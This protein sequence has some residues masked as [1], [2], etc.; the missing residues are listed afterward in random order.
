[1]ND[2]YFVI[3]QDDNYDDFYT[4][5]NAQRARELAKSGRFQEF[6]PIDDNVSEPYI[7]ELLKAPDFLVFEEF[8]LLL[9]GID[10]SGFDLIPV[11][12]KSDN[13]FE[14]YY[15][16]DFKEYISCF[17]KENSEFDSITLSV[18]GLKKLVLDEEILKNTPEDKRQFFCLKESSDIKIAS[19]EFVDHIK[20]V[21][22]EVFDMDLEGF[23]FIPVSEYKDRI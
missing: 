9:K 23:K 14:D 3:V 10:A 4:S 16:I 8:P 7:G 11:K 15:L 13:G 19:K 5:G 2:N 22:K 20:R 18:H 17:D 12:V 6:Y 21:Y 1:M